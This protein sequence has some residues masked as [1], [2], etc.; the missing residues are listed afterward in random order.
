MMLQGEVSRPR[1]AMGLLGMRP[2]DSD[3]PTDPDMS[4][5]RWSGA[6]HERILLVEDD[7]SIRDVLRAILEEEGYAVTTAENGRRALEH[8]RSGGAPDLIVL[9]LRMPI[10]DGWQFRAMQKADPVLAT[11]PVL[12]VSAD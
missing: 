9:D 8:L 2:P 12:A 7:R 4:G 10:M 1:G 3:E 6:A 11:I 5:D